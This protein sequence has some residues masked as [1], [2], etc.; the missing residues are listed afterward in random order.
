M[1][2]NYNYLIN[3]IKFLLILQSARSVIFF[4]TFVCG[5]VEVFQPQ[6][7]TDA[8]NVS[9]LGSFSLLIGMS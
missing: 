8:D 5:G 9:P 7:S 4:T 2:L 1:Q 6:D 3:F